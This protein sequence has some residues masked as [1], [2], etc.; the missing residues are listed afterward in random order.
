MEQWNTERNS[1]ELIE[2]IRK[3]ILVP[4][5]VNWTIEDGEFVEGQNQSETLLGK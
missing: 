3:I 4:A 1:S 5:G 2:Q